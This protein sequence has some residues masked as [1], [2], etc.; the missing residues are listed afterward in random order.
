MDIRQARREFKFQLNERQAAAVIADISGMLPSDVNGASGAYPIIS[1]AYDTD[2]RDVYWERYRKMPN[3]R[4]LRVRIYGTSNGTIPPTAFLEIK[5]KRDGVGVKRRM[6]VPLEGVT[7][8]NFDVAE[9]VRDLQPG[10]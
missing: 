3:R 9:L 1:E 7:S 4:K 6:T 10:L 5:H 2:E 8:K